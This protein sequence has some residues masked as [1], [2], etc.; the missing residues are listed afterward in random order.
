MATGIIQALPTAGT[1]G[2]IQLTDPATDPN[3]N[4]TI[5]FDT[6]PSG[7]VI[8]CSVTFD[9]VLSGRI[10]IAQNVQLVT[11]A[12]G[13][14]QTLPTAGGSGQI[15][16]VNPATD[17]NGNTT[18]A[19]DTAP[20]GAVINAAVSFDIVLS[21][22]VFIAQNVKLIDNGPVDQGDVKTGIVTGNLT[23]DGAS[24]TTTVTLKGA[25]V[26]GNVQVR[27]G[28]K[29]IIKPDASGAKTTLSKGLTANKNSVIVL[30]KSEIMGTVAVTNCQSFMATGST[31][32]SS[33]ILVNNGTVSVDGTAVDGD[34]VVNNSTVSA[35]VKNS[36]ITGNLDM[37]NN[38]GCNQTNN[39]VGGTNSGC[40]A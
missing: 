8:N 17:P 37:H 33:L 1:S 24:A 15:Q 22:R 10:Y 14:I 25:T 6:A 21:G 38:T 20:S 4:T 39:N 12:T 16:L 35:T 34:V 40:V 30:Y 7:A 9:F 23:V 3:G 27:N 18:I 2:Q 32:D 26:S 28:G 29:L 31:V 5:A 11:T 19:Y 36:N 13:I